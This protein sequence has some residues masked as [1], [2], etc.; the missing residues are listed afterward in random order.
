MPQYLGGPAN[1]ATVPL[2]AAYHQMITNAFRQAWPYGQAVPSAA[3]LKQIM[4]D[5]YSRFPLS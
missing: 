5:V 3:K 4:N 1:G 2:D